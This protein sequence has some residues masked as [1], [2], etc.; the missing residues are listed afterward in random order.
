LKISEERLVLPLQKIYLL[1]LSCLQKFQNK[2]TIISKYLDLKCLNSFEDAA[3]INE[4]ETTSLRKNN[5]VIKE[6]IM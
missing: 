3:D 5:I 1:L 4:K 6:V 2:E